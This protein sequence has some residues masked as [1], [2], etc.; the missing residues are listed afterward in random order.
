MV[1]EISNEL[2]SEIETVEEDAL[3]I[4]ELITEE[5]EAGV[6]VTVSM[7]GN[8]VGVLSEG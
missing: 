2:E 4:V 6:G 8:I 1:E 5:P 7:Y 3:V